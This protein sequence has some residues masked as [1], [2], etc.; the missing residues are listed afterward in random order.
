MDFYVLYFTEPLD[1][2]EFSAAQKLIYLPLYGL[3]GSSCYLLVLLFQNRMYLKN[4]KQWSLKSELL[5]FTFIILISFVVMR[6]FYLYIIVYGEPNPYSLPYY[7]KTI[8][9]PALLVILPIIIIG[10]FAF[11]KYKETQVEEQKIEIK[12][13]GN[14]DG[15]KL[16][17]TDLISL[18]ASDNYVEVFYDDKG[19][20]KKT[21][22]RARL[23]DIEKN[24]PNL[25]RTHRSYV[26]N[27]TH[28][29]SFSKEK[30][31]LELMLSHTTFVPVSKTYATAVK[32]QLNFATQ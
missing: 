17:P 11:G 7:L 26:I 22:I 27:P 21:L 25:L 6:S 4:N 30:G 13:D 1:V 29:I 32:S 23:S 31:K 18:V 9:I 24:V 28:F 8:F 12:G 14:Y 10:R 3:L 5:I 16:F 2:N 20:L 15:I 19:V